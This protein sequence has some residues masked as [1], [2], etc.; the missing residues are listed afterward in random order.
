VGHSAAAATGAEPEV[1][2]AGEAAAVGNDGSAAFDPPL[3]A[4]R[5]AELRRPATQAPTRT[6]LTTSEKLP[7]IG[8]ADRP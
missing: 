8:A 4:A 7:G 3:Q 1:V 2:G 5:R 6:E